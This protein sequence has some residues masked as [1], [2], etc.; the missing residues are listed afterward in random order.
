M[1][2][3]SDQESARLREENVRLHKLLAALEV[4]LKQSNQ[5]VAELTKQLATSLNGNKELTKQLKKTQEKLDILIA[6]MKKRNQRDYGPTTE[7]HN[8]QK[9]TRSASPG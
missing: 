5:S 8:P 1:A 6:R 9:G 3:S 7:K 2:K 4:Q